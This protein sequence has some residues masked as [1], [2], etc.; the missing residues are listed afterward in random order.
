VT[1]PKLYSKIL[2][3]FLLAYAVPLLGQSPAPGTA[4]T[5]VPLPGSG[6]DYIQGFSETVDPASGGVSMRINVPIPQGHALTLPFS[7]AYD[8]NGIFVPMPG[9]TFQHFSVGLMSAGGWS[10]TVPAAAT[11]VDFL[12]HKLFAMTRLPLGKEQSRRIET[13]SP[14]GVASDGKRFKKQIQLPNEN[15]DFPFGWLALP[16]RR[17][18]VSRLEIFRSFLK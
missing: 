6:H 8:S 16:T 4:S 13:D 12:F 2:T 5:W 10:Y 9:S 18:R 3:F 15:Q 17:P 1:P 14:I 11:D 7:F